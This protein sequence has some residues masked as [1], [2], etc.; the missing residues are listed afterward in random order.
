M[1][2]KIFYSVL[3]TVCILVIM[4]Y[5]DITDIQTIRQYTT[6]HYSPLQH[7]QHHGGGD[8][9]KDD[10]KDSVVGVDGIDSVDDDDG[11]DGVDEDDGYDIF[12]ERIRKVR[13][14]CAAEDLSP[15]SPTPVNPII[16][17]VEEKHN[18]LM[19]RT[20]KHGSTTW[21]SIFVKIYT[22]GSVCQSIKYPNQCEV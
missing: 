11:K 3:S 10:G 21:A 2:R 19:C 8:D 13:S 1:L 22:K 4:I 20:A 6:I 15:P 5:T 16:W 7:L 12:D 18:L 17:S 14:A 9:N